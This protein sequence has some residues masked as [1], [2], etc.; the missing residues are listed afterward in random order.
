[1]RI[2]VEEKKGVVDGSKKKGEKKKEGV[3]F[4]E[5]G[6]DGNASGENELPTATTAID[7]SNDTSTNKSTRLQKRLQKAV[8]RIPPPHEPPSTPPQPPRATVTPRGAHTGLHHNRRPIDCCTAPT[9][10]W[11]CGG[12]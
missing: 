11:L 10:V 2:V 4:D 9:R 3:E 1:M 8:N 7:Q 12:R 6:N 5:E